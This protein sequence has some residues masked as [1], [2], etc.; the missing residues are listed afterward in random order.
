VLVHNHFAWWVGEGYGIKTTF[1]HSFYQ[2]SFSKC[3]VEAVLSLF[4]ITIIIISSTQDQ[5]ASTLY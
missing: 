1:P 2:M 3:S 4:L 5:Q